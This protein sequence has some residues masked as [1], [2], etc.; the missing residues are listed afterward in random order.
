MGPCCHPLPLVLYVGEEMHPCRG[1]ARA[2]RLYQ[3]RP[4]LG[5]RAGAEEVQL[6]GN[7]AEQRSPRGG[8]AAAP[9]QG[10]LPRALVLA[11]GEE[12]LTE[13]GPAD[14]AEELWHRLERRDLGPGWPERHT[15]PSPERTAAL[16]RSTRAEEPQRSED[17][18]G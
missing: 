7:H 14:Q 17:D 5:G 16:R 3:G 9:W 6:G 10:R 18:G 2:V 13:E 8:K 11:A 12:T 15:A 4:P 1:G